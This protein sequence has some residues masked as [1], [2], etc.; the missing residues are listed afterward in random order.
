MSF[1]VGFTGHMTQV[2]QGITP[3][4]ALFNLALS[5]ARRVPLRLKDR[6]PYQHRIPSACLTQY[7]TYYL[8]ASPKPW[9]SACPVD[10]APRP[11]GRKDSW[12]SV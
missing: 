2:S 4:G 5:A 6:H 12:T 11:Q 1:R 7:A 3:P 9:C 8:G 10:V